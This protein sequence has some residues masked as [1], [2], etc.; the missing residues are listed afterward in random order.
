MVIE[1]PS[2]SDEA[3]VK[4]N[5]AVQSA[6]PGR[7]LTEFERGRLVTAGHVYLVLHSGRDW[8]K[9]FGGRFVAN[10][11]NIGSLAASLT[12]ELMEA[13]ARAAPPLKF[14][15][16]IKRLQ[17]LQERAS[18]LAKKGPL[19]SPRED[20]FREVLGTW[21]KIGGELKY[22]RNPNSKKLGGPL[23]RFFGAVTSPVLGADAPA[24]ESIKD[25]IDREKKRLMGK[26]AA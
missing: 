23:V 5:S 7:T 21:M 26:R 13:D 17:K 22:S 9:Q 16:L 8:L 25:I 20:Y 14:R 24:L 19:T 4:I 12:D 2:Y 1:R 18:P 10:W 15:G 6:R 3:W 11:E